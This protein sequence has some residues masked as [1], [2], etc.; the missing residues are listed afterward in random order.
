M[1]IETYSG[2]RAARRAQGRRRRRSAKTTATALAVATAAFGMSTMV[3]GPAAAEPIQG[4]VTGGTTQEGVTSGAQTGG[5]TTTTPA[6]TVSEPK[7]ESSFWVA[8]PAQYNQGTRAYDPQTGGG[9][10]VVDYSTDYTDYTD[11]TG[12]YSTDYS[13]GG[14]WNA[15]PTPQAPAPAVVAGPTLPIEAPAD[16]MRFGR[17]IF[18]QPAWV[19]DID[20]ERTNRTTAVIEAMVTD[21]HKSTGTMDSDEAEKLASAQVAGTAVGTGVGFVTGCTAAG[22]PTAL[23]LA[24]VGGIGGAG[25]G[26]M[27]PLPV[28]GVAPV[29]SG[30]AGTGLGAAVGFGVGCAV[31]GGLGALG[32][33]LAGYG[34]GT[35][36]G[37]GEDAT[38]IEVEVPEVE[39]EQITE[40][41]DT[42]LAQWSQDPVGATV[43]EAVQTFTT[44]TA[45]TIDTQVRDFVAVQPG[46]E[47]LIEQVD[48]G[49]E[50]FFTDA[51][52]GLAGNLITNAIGDG[53]AQFGI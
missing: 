37:A 45:P 47:Q 33:G 10:T 12:G 30:V 1:S 43:V 31:G 51:T 24:T 6:P 39:S 3:A 5:T 48:Q 27:V 50:S 2:N 40:Q 53:I 21:L 28:P 17:V 23:A 29:T 42:T 18:D 9:V 14:T 20:A 22:V 7:A 46:G 34:L 4:G 35:A 26:T 25:L 52:P 44:D 11:Y 36:Y 49:L 19:S 15:E 32:G 16:K 8:P 41:V 38:P 13:G